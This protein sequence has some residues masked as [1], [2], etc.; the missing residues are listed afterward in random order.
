M[1]SQTKP[2][3]TKDEDKTTTLIQGTGSNYKS[4]ALS[5]HVDDE[6]KLNNET[7]S[8]LGRGGYSRVPKR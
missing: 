5:D 7:L 2:S 4:K 1:T 3:S 8:S 6:D